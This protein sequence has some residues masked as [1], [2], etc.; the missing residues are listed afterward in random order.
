VDVAN[1]VDLEELHSNLL[2]L[3]GFLASV[4]HR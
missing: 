4:Q 3:L 1:G 2:H